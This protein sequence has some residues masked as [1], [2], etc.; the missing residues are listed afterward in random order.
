MNKCVLSASVMVAVIFQI[1]AE[2]ADY[3]KASEINSARHGR[4]VV[5]YVKEF[6]SPCLK[7]QVLGPSQKWKILADKSFC[8]YE[9][10]SFLTDVTYASFDDLKF[11]SDGIHTTL[12]ITP[13]QLTND[14]VRS[15][16]I[17]IQEG[18]VSDISC[19]ISK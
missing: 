13:L 1:S 5:R 6:G 16:I 11:E 18:E 17:P 19:T 2:A 12:T 14:V 15:C 10:K 9:G 7:V 4:E 3:G 8:S